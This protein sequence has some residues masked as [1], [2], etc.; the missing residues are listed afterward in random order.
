MTLY[1][2]RLGTGP[3]LVL[4]H[5]WGMNGAVFDGI[6]TELSKQ[7]RL[8]IIDL[9]GFGYSADLGIEDPDLS[10]WLDLML[11]ALPERAHLLGWSLGGMLAIRLAFLYPERVLSLITVASSPRFVAE[12]EWP[13][14]KPEVLTS[15]LAQLQADTHKTLERFLAIQALGSASARDDVRILR[16]RLQSRPAPLHQALRMG[17]SLLQELDLRAE[18]TTLDIPSLHLFGRLD[19]LVPARV[20]DVWPRASASNAVLHLFVD[21]SHAPFIT[22]TVEFIRV[23]SEFIAT[24]SRNNLPYTVALVNN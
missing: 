14:V 12:P 5:G 24:R 22:E 1:V 23:V 16:E 21:S 10:S 15:F 20:L 3:D 11:K 19:G 6:K 4:L 13:G 17:L 9:P 8:H 2:E 7:F 18:L